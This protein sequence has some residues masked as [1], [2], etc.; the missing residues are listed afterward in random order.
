MILLT[1]ALRE[2]MRVAL[3]EAV[4]KDLTPGADAHR[5]YRQVLAATPAGTWLNDEHALVDVIEY[6]QI[7]VE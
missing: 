6:F 2:D 1:N 7:E 3:D 4:L 5:A